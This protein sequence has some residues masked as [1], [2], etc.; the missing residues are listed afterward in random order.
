VSPREREDLADQV[1]VAFKGVLAARRRLRALESRRH[2]E[3]SDAQYSL[4]FGLCDRAELSTSELA[5]S[6]DLSP[7]SVTEMLEGLVAAGLVQRA[8]SARDRRVVLTSLTGRGR[9]L[10]EQRRAYFE[11]RYRAALAEFSDEQ[12]RNTAAVLDRLR[13]LF[14]G[15]ADERSA[16]RDQA[17]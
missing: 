13:V 3:L 5:E 9:I 1:G 8:R 10:V 16:E 7:P 6:A 12:L 14:V 17:V 2:D 11:P 4:L 15:L